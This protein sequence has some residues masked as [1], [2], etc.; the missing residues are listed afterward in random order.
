MSALA[1]VAA[2]QP[3]DDENLNQLSSSLATVSIQSTASRL[4]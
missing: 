2:R 3:L 1:A 4:V